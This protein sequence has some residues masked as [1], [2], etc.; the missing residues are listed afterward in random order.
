V[1]TDSAQSGYPATNAADGNPN[2][3]WHTAYTPNTAPLPH[4][5]VL[6]LGTTQL[7]TGLSYLA[8]Q[9]G[10]ANGSISKYEL[11]VST[12]GISWGSPLASGTFNYGTSS[13]TCPGWIVP[14]A[15]T[16]TIPPTAARYMRLRALSEVAG[17]AYTS[18]AEVTPL[19]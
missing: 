12:D 8:R 9:D 11:Y 6:D 2:T 4:D 18:A 10:C 15:Q 7:V 13:F 3:L 1:Q 14:A 5:I 17:N 16:I 19:F